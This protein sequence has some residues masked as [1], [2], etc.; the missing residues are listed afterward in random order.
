MFIPIPD[1][2]S[3]SKNQ[4]TWV[5]LPKKL[6]LSSRKYDSVCS[7]CRIPVPDL[8][9]LPIPDPDPQHY[10]FLMFCPPRNLIR[11]DSVKTMDALFACIEAQKV[12]MLEALLQ[13]VKDVNVRHEETGL[14]LLHKAAAS[15]HSDAN[16]FI[17]WGGDFS[18]QHLKCYVIGLTL[19][20]FVKILGPNLLQSNLSNGLNSEKK[21]FFCLSAKKFYCLLVNP[22]VVLPLQKK[23][24]HEDRR[25][26]TQNFFTYIH[27]RLYMRVQYLPVCVLI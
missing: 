12:G 7:S 27:K 15:G 6:I 2:G 9:F 17:L 23:F 5:F 20:A 24:V 11:T 1:P 14:G 22:V 26:S 25:F 10:L 18:L 4:R 21:S 16:T 8:Y 3:A 19:G 13:D